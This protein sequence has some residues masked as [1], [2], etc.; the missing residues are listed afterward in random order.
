VTAS[1]R[2]ARARGTHAEETRVHTRLQRVALAVEESRAYWSNVD[3]TVP[4]AKRAIDAFEGRWFGA[5]SLDR[6]R[7]LLPNLA[8]RY[9]DFPRALTVLRGWRAMEPETRVVVCHWHLQLSDPLYRAFTGELLPAR[10]ASLGALVDRDT[11]LRWLRIDLAARWGERT[12]AQ[13]AGKLLSAA[14]EAGLVSSPPDPRRVLAPKVPDEAL[15]YL[16]YL[17][18]ETRFA[19][20]LVDNPYLRSV[21]LA[22]SA[23]DHRLRATPG[24]RL[25]RAGDLVEFEWLATDLTAWAG[26]RA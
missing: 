18:R 11:V 26:A 17:L 25:R 3:P 1:P 8:A 9:D 24:V 7:V 16:L 13:V 10:R 21:G 14:T 5:R 15:A 2:P 22:G 6:I 12:L 23:L 19:G 20:S 4:A